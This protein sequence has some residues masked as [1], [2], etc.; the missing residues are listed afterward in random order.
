MLGAGCQ[1]QRGTGDYAKT[2]SMLK[3]N[4]FGCLASEGHK[5]AKIETLEEFK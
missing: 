5:R 2:L 1:A 3:G 4:M